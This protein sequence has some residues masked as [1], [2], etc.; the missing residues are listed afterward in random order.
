MGDLNRDA[1]TTKQREEQEQKKGEEYERKKEE[2]RKRKEEQQK[3]D[4]EV[5]HKLAEEREK[6]KAEEEA[7][8]PP[9]GEAEGEDHHEPENK[10]DE[11]ENKDAP[12]ALRKRAAIDTSEGAPEEGQEAAQ[13]ERRAPTE[14]TYDDDDE[15][16]PAPQPGPGENSPE[17]YTLCSPQLL[18]LDI[19][20]SPLW[21]NGWL[22]DNKFAD[23][24]KKKFGTFKHYLMEPKTMREPTPWQLHENNECCLTVERER[25]RV[26]SK[27][28]KALLARMMEK[29]RQVGAPGS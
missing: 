23:K 12:K 29:A 10:R 9:P 7:K 24:S 4:E 8:K 5:Q 25:M 27:E 15:P 28:E 22:L 1:V 17:S 11:N 20:G 13:P 2:E 18:H 3:K 16:T 6:K 14:V 26:F 21:F 19:D